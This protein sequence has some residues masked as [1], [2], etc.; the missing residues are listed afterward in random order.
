M[1]PVTPEQVAWLE[2]YVQR[3][4]NRTNDTYWVF[5][6]QRRGA[7]APMMEAAHREHFAA[8]VLRRATEQ[9]TLGSRP[10]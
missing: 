1:P 10:E 2:G 3:L 9:R 8:N 4:H 7:L 5:T 6:R